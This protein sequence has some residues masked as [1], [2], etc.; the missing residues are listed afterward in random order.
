MKKH[1][2]K[3]EACRSCCGMNTRE[4]AAEYRLSHWAGI[5]RERQESGL[6]IRQ[7]CKNAGYHENVYYYWQRRLREAACQELDPAAQ[8]ER[9]MASAPEGWVSCV[10]PERSTSQPMLAIEIG[11][12]R[13]VVGND[14]ESEHLVKVCRALASIC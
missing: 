13:V 3:N 1:M 11:P 4:I 6:S 8:E 5:M 12:Y 9:R 2:W 14:I 7:F 10:K